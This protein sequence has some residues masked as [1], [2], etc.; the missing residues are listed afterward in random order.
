MS[1]NERMQWKQKDIRI[2]RAPVIVHEDPMDTAGP[3]LTEA[4]VRLK[5]S[6][7]CGGK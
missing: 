4:A 6:K 3:V 2:E 7:Q 5:K 1:E